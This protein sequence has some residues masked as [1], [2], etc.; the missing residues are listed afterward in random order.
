MKVSVY[1]LPAQKFLSSYGQDLQ[2]HRHDGREVVLK[3]KGDWVYGVVAAMPREELERLVDTDHIAML[4]QF[5]A[6]GGMEYYNS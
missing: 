2:D 5:L 4:E 1:I 3:Q 6:Q